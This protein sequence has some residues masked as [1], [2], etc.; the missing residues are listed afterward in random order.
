MATINWD[1]LQKRMNSDDDR[2]EVLELLKNIKERLPELGKLLEQVNGH[3]GS[4]DMMYRYYHHSFKVYDIQ[5]LTFK[6]VE[7][8][9]SLLPD[10]ELDEFFLHILA[11]GTGKEFQ[12][13][14]NQRWEAETRPLLEAFFH[15]RYFLEMAIKYGKKMEKPPRL[16]PSG[17]AALLSL[18]QL[19]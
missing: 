10:A 14:H 9:K 6:I 12:H 18:Y 3:W 1:E 7:A 5:N 11:D 17:W 4:E 19:R 15:S 8:L 16:L 2:P 13:E